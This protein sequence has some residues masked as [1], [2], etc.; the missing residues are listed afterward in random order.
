MFKLENVIEF[1]SLILRC[2]LVLIIFG[3]LLP[4]IID[5]VLYYFYKTNIYDNSIF[6]NFLVD[7]NMKILY[8][9]IYIIKKVISNF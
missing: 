3:M 5:G 7:K 1:I 9:Y 2:F 8:N 6:V 4:K